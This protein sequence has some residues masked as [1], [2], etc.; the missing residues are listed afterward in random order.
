MLIYASIAINLY[1]RMTF[2]IC[3]RRGDYD[4]LP[5][6]KP[7]VSPVEKEAV[8]PATRTASKK[9]SGTQVEVK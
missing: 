6:P 2:L 4:G 1:I 9:I 5:E 3:K 7:P 8:S